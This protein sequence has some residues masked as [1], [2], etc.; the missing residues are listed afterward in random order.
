MELFANSL[1]TTSSDDMQCEKHESTNEDI[2]IIKNCQE[3]N[4]LK[5]KVQKYQSHN[6]TFTCQKKMKSFTIKE[7][8][9]HG[10]LDGIK[11][12]QVLSNITVCRFKFPKFPLDETRLIL[13]IPKDT[14]ESIVKKR[15]SDLNKIIK[16]LIRQTHTD[17]DLKELNSWKHLQGMD[18]WQFLYE[19][20]MFK[21][22]KLL[23]DCN[24]QD[25]IE[26]KER[27]INAISASV[28][29]TAMM[30]LKRKV[31]DVFVNGYNP[32]I[33]RLHQANHDLQICIDQYSCAQYICGYLT[34]NESGMSKLLRAVNEETNNLKQ[35]DKLNAL[36]S[37]LDK[38]R[39]VSIQ[40]AVYRL[41]G[42]SMT[43]SSVVV[44]YLSTIHPNHRDGLLKGNIDDLEDG[45]SI[46]HKSPHEYWE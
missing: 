17:Q 42:L 35:A 16:Y 5:E 24:D 7:S 26:A 39:E 41:L 29:G 25:K 11:Y 44:K 33:M 31:K 10:K 1:I 40:E 12:G 18:F 27:Y 14:D 6:H 37:V 21:S 19:A 8:E 13:G 38:H 36:A 15:K 43:K 9:G 2:A 34:K 30:V 22:D 4:Y 46:F 32:T 23:S 45:E 28:Q 3:C 20:G